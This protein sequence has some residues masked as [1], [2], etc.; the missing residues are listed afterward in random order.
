MAED[1]DDKPDRKDIAKA[2]IGNDEA[3]RARAE[4]TKQIVELQ[5]GNRALR[6]ALQNVGGLS[7]IEQATKAL[8]P[9]SAVQG[10][11]AS[12]SAAGLA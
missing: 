5:A 7:A 9:L 10:H 6:S 12:V 3:Q 8:A 11:L 1:G 2:G 4:H